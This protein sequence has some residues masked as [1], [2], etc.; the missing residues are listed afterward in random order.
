MNHECV[1]EGELRALDGSIKAFVSSVETLAAQQREVLG[2][3]SKV[4][5][6]LQQNAVNRSEIKA[7]GEKIDR[8]REDV[9]EEQ[10]TQW[11]KIDELRKDQ[12]EHVERCPGPHAS[13]EALSLSRQA[14]DLAKQM[15]KF[16]EEERGAKKLATEAMT[17][18][19]NLKQRPGRWALAGWIAVGGTAQAV[20]ITVIVHYLTKP[21]G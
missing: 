2:N 17:A 14:L 9:K 13:A 19:E 20:I 12:R 15:A 8:L 10:R 21:G 6:V 3:L 7:L 5:E 11:S 1:K 16:I 18:V 4:T